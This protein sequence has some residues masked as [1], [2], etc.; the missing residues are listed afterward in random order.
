MSDPYLRE[1]LLHRLEEGNL[2][3]QRDSDVRDAAGISPEHS[4]G[5][6]N[7]AMGR[8]VEGRIVRRSRRQP[9]SIGDTDCPIT[10]SLR[11]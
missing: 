10:Y 7:R 8:L 1:V 4:K 6:V 9:E 2:R 5:Q 11:I 3:V